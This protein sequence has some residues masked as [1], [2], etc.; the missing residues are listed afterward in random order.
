MNTGGDWGGWPLHGA[1]TDLQGWDRILEPREMR[2]WARCEEVGPGP[3][4]L[5]SWDQARLRT[6]N[7]TEFTVSQAELCQAAT[8]R[9]NIQA[10]ANRN[11]FYES[12]RFCESLA[13]KMAVA[14]DGVSLAM[15]N[16]TQTE[17]CGAGWFYAGYTEV[18][19]EDRWLE[20]NTGQPLAWQNW[21]EREPNNWGGNEDCIAGASWAAGF[22]DI[23][24]QAKICPICQGRC[25]T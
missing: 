21:A 25:L 22:F 2:A 19:G 3:G 14:E 4:N 18:G 13:A 24:C 15:M 7:I 11:D 23:K 17:V 10:F 9:Q 6:N 20:V 12:Q 1:V 5:V 16:R 8:A